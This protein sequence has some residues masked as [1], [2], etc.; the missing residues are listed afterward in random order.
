MIVRE[1]VMLGGRPLT[2]ETGR[3]AKQAEASVLISDGDT[4]VLVT[5]CY[6]EPRFGVSF[7]PLTCD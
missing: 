3:L 6:G 1:S 7:F 4:Q 2:I 5:L